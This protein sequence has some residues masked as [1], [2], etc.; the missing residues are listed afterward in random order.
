MHWWKLTDLVPACYEFFYGEKMN[1][2]RRRFQAR[3]AKTRNQQ[4]RL[5][6]RG[7]LLALSLI[8][9]SAFVLSRPASSRSPSE[10]QS[11]ASY[12]ASA[13]LQKNCVSAESRERSSDTDGADLGVAPRKVCL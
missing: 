7:F 5:F 4:G 2:S 1:G 11:P 9:L 10:A 3:S 12:P 8:H 6:G 13:T